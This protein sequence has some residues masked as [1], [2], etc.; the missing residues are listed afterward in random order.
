MAPLHPIG[1]FEVVKKRAGP[2]SNW[3]SSAPACAEPYFSKRIYYIAYRSILMPFCPQYTHRRSQPSKTAGL[4]SLRVLSCHNTF[5]YIPIHGYT[6]RVSLAQSH[7]RHGQVL[8]HCILT[9]RAYCIVC[10]HLSYC[11]RGA[12]ILMLGPQPRDFGR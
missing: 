8:I 6:L 7:I 1:P 5:I 9:L 2:R 3:T 12:Y 10:T 11:A 4:S